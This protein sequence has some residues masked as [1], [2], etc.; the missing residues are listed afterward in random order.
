MKMY[1]H[2]KTCTQMVIPVLF[3]IAKCENK[4]DEWINEM[5]CIHTILLS[6]KNKLNTDIIQN[7]KIN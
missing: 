5:C 3:L 2:R 4:P 6:N 7:T 1:V